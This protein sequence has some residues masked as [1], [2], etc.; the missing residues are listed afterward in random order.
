M[1]DDILHFGFVEAFSD[2]DGEGAGGGGQKGG[3]GG[4]C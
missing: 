2:Y 3:E 4:F 1:L